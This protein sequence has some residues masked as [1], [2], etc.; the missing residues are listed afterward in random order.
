MFGFVECNVDWQA[1]TCRSD[2]Q[3]TLRDLWPYSSFV[4]SSVPTVTNNQSQYLPGGTCT[5]VVDKWATRV[6]EKGSDQIFGL[7]TW[8]TMAGKNHARITLITVYRVGNKVS[9]KELVRSTAR[10]QQMRMMRAQGQ[11]SD[12]RDQTIVDI[13]YLINEF[14][15]QGHSIV[16]SWDANEAKAQTPAESGVNQELLECDL[17]DA[18]ECMHPVS[19]PPATH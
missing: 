8:V 3:S 13:I 7:Y 10:A 16:L 11:T 18:H 19:S 6:L 15:A 5:T 4:T 12:P 2:W 14:K 9:D 1:L 17:V